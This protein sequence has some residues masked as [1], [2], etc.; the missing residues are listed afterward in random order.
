MLKVIKSDGTAEDYIGSKILRTLHN[1]LAKIE[2]DNITIAE[3]L[4]EVITF[5]L[6]NKVDRKVIT[7]SE[8]HSILK[9]ILASSG[10]EDAAGN[11]H[12]H[13]YHRLMKRGRVFVVDI[14]IQ[15]LYDAKMFHNI[16]NMGI[17]E[18]WNKSKIVEWV[19]ANTGLD[20]LDARAVA[21]AVEEKI[22]TTNLT[23][24]TTG[25]IKQFVLAE[26]A[27]L[28]IN[29]QS[30]NSQLVSVQD[31]R[32]ITDVDCLAETAHEEEYVMV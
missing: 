7:S 27:D 23:C 10:F 3:Q 2:Q 8:M 28:I 9:I 5:Y 11:L 30:L 29:S 19:R 31:E 4:T 20:C 16:K 13:H 26:T 14:D 18:Q 15:T 22:F 24:L 32:L 17:F 1:C 6:Y 21:S 25:L 12:E